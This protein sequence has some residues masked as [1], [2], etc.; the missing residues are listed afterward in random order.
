MNQSKLNKVLLI[1][2]KMRDRFPNLSKDAFLEKI[3]YYAVK[4]YGHQC[5]STVENNADRV[6]SEYSGE[7][8]VHETEGQISDYKPGQSA[9]IKSA[10]GVTTTVDLK[11]NPTALTK[12][13]TGKLKLT[14]TPSTTSSTT[15][16]PQPPKPGDKVE[17]GEGVSRLLKLAGLM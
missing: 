3:E 6:W 16:A 10:N 15:P 17:M 11:T 9:T 1:A 14:T 2:Q 12:D 8:Q 13:A 5:A 7:S 4:K